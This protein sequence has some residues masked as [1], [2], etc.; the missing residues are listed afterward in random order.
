[1]RPMRGLQTDRSA[2]VVI[3]GH[4]FVPDLRRGHYELA[5]DAVPALRAEATDRS[6]PGQV[7]SWV[8]SLPA[9]VYTG[10]SAVTFGAVGVLLVRCRGVPGTAAPT[11]RVVS[12]LRSRLASD[13]LPVAAG[14]CEALREIAGTDIRYVADAATAA[15]EEAA[16]RPSESELRFGEVAVGADAGSRIVR[17]LGPPLAR[18][19]T[20]RPSESW[21][22][23][24]ETA[25]GVAVSVATDRA[26]THRGELTVSGPTGEFSFPSTSRSGN[27]RRRRLPQPAARRSHRQP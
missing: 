15:L 5:A 16:I 18:A 6:G 14:A 22:T 27:H 4:A 20:V 26:G 17:L 3:A 11:G 8:W 12:E 10:G 25:E 13:H 23:A 19:C 7:E 1:L 21:I 2:Q 24:T 9:R